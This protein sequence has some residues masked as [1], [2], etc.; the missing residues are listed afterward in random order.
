[1]ADAHV[2]HGV[3]DGPRGGMHR[4]HPREPPRRGHDAGEG[5]QVGDAVRGDAAAEPGL[6]RGLAVSLQVHADPVHA[7][8]DCGRRARGLHGERG[9]DEP[10][11]STT[12]MSAVSCGSRTLSGAACA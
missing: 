11:Q 12:G 4:V 8:G 2:Q 7:G 10:A 3:Q 6:P 1:V 9:Q 5:L